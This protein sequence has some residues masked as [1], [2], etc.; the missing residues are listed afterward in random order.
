M[1]FI[2][3]DGD[4]RIVMWGDHWPACAKCR[5]VDVAKSATFV[6]ACAQGSPLLMEEL[7]RRQAPVEKEKRATVLEWARKVGVFPT[8]RG[9]NVPMK[10]KE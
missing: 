7:A 6:N 1:K 10:Y 5:E 4:T 9:K 2:D 8:A 3:K